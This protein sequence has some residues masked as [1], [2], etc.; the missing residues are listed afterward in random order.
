[1]GLSYEIPYLMAAHRY[2][3]VID[4]CKIILNQ[5]DTLSS[6]WT[7]VAE[8]LAEAYRLSG[9]FEEASS[10]YNE[11]NKVKDELYTMQNSSTVKEMATAYKIKERDQEIQL[12]QETIKY[13]KR[14]VVILIGIIIA[15]VIMV[16]YIYSTGKALKAKNKKLYENIHNA[17]VSNKSSYNSGNSEL[18]DA[19]YKIISE[20]LFLK[21]D[22]NRKEMA[23][24][25]GINENRLYSYIKEI[26]DLPV[27][28]YLN[29]LRLI[30]SLSLLDASAK[31]RDSIE[32]IA[33]SSGF[34]NVRTY[35][36][37]FKAQYG[38]TPSEYQRLAQ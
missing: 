14:M 5:T 13:Q 27:A 6:Y 32:G 31:S 1:M 9:Q 30:Y 18:D 26:T 37:L 38:I 35:Q 12:Q 23:K 19:L 3:K 33:Y 16:W 28:S 36:R 15:L 29:S 21:E 22:F 2:S 17:S 20:K 7:E 24:V 25:M 10:L 8:N 4:D 34:A 11:L